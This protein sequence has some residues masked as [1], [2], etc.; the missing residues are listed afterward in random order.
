MHYKAQRYHHLQLHYFSW[1]VKM[2]KLPLQILLFSCMLFLRSWIQ[3]SESFPWST[4]TWAIRLFQMKIKQVCILDV[5]PGRSET[6]ARFSAQGK[7]WRYQWHTVGT[8][9][10][11]FSLS[12]WLNPFIIHWDSSILSSY[13]H[14]YCQASFQPL[15]RRHTTNFS[16]IPD[17]V[18]VVIGRL[19]ESIMTGHIQVGYTA[20]R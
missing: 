15:N 5:N 13:N 8:F 20:T 19:T 18:I 9:L 16:Q 1:A 4:V 3:N 6:S 14:I 2:Q 11:H 10:A 7:W 12:I 17:H